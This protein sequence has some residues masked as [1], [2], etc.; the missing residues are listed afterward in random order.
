VQVARLE[1]KLEER[2]SDLDKANAVN[3]NFREEISK[4]KE[5]V[6]ELRGR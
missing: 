3:E 5:M 4:N 6:A 1:T 2:I